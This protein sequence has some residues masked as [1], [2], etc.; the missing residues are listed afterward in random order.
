MDRVNSGDGGNTKIQESQQNIEIS[1]PVKEAKTFTISSILG[2]EPPDLLG[3]AA[4][5]RKEFDFDSKP[6]KLHTDATLRL[7]QPDTVLHPQAMYPHPGGPAA[8]GQPAGVG[9]P[10]PLYQTPGMLQM[11]EAAWVMYR[12]QLLGLHGMFSFY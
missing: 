1:S 6:G 12:N 5:R 11:N 3:I 9:G 7:S 4:E 10:M 2:V 8:L